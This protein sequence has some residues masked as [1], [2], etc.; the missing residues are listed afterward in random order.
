MKE[1]KVDEFAVKLRITGT[2]PPSYAFNLF[3][4]KVKNKKFKD[5]KSRDLELLEGMKGK[6]FELSELIN[7]DDRVTYICA[8]PG[9]GKSVLSKQLAYRWA[10]GKIYTNYKFCIMMECRDINYF[11]LHEGT[12]LSKHE[13]FSEFLK[14][15]FDYDLGDAAGTL[16]IVDGLD[17]LLDIKENDSLIWQLLDIHNSKYTKAKIILTGRPQVERTLDSYN[18]EVGGM[19]KIEILG[20]SEEQ[21]NEYVT[22]FASCEEEIVKINKVKNSSIA[23]LP[24]I[25][26]PQFLNSLC[27]VAILSKGEAVRSAAELYCWT[28]YL[29]LK[30]HAEKGGSREKLCS[31]I[32]EEYS[33][34]L[35]VLCKICHEL[36][37]ES[38]IIFEGN[39]PWRLLKGGKRK[40]FFEGLFTDVSDNRKRRFQFQHL[41]L[42]EILSA[43]HI[44][45]MKSR[46]EA[47]EDNMRKGLYQVVLFSC[48]L[49]A[50]LKYDGIIQDVFI[51]DEELQ[52]INVQHFLPHVLEL[53]IQSIS[54][55]GYFRRKLQE[56]SFQLC[57]DIIMS[58]T[59]KD[60]ASK[61][62][63]ASTI[64]KLRYEG[65]EFRV[66]SL[67]KVNDICKL[68]EV[69]YQYC[70][71][72]LK[73]ILQNV[74]VEL[75]VVDDV[76]VLTPLQ[77]FAI[78]REIELRGLETSV[79]LL[80][81]KIAEITKCEKVIIKHCKLVDERAIDLR[82]VKFSLKW[83]RIDSCQL[84]KKSFINVCKWAATS[85]EELTLI[86]IDKIEDSW[87][88]ELAGA[89]ANE[90]ERKT[91]NLA[92]KKLKVNSC[93]QII[94]SKLK[95]RVSIN[96]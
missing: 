75:V 95:I 34:E 22:M 26:V 76:N 45:G 30:Q 15:K 6:R 42:M 16:F 12:D 64:K 10:N 66:Q 60:V 63:I 52:A 89:I 29:L 9:M 17:E 36:L 70:E 40:E 3:E 57:L 37:N 58:F 54:F 20:L 72:D 87:W 94:S 73:E 53:A 74:F 67:K 49:I 18:R 50:G 51:N 90:Y 21:V 44:C 88:E 82:K 13:I 8:I 39:V 46:M 38:T 4:N 31:E 84:I 65:A 61:Q 1:V 59:N 7:H 33:S 43:I 93:T 77:C 62:F 14:S 55:E 41:T 91:G 2:T 5:E 81:N 48:Q 80:Q 32:F 11:V 19:Q 56:Q 86:S 24:V 96:L 25:Y 71:E 35:L 23:Y 85:I 92:L 27:C 69:E 68:L 78:V 79:S 47:I 83:V 28:L